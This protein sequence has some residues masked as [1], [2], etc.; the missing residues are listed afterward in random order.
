ME[1]VA[2]KI[3]SANRSY[4]RKIKEAVQ[5]LFFRHH[6]LPGVRGWEIRQELGPDWQEIIR[7]LDEQL[8]PLD[9]KVTRIYDEP[10]IIEKPTQTQL[11]NAR[12]YITMRSTL[13]QKIAKTI[14]W[15]VDDIAGLAVTVAYII[16]KQGKAPRIEVEKI[17]QEKLPGWRVKINLDRYIE[18]GY[19]GEQ[20][21]GVL[22]LEWRSRAEIDQKKLIALIM[23]FN[24]KRTTQ[25]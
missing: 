15:R 12:Y 17:L 6:R 25:V 20:D 8:V 19:L 18:Q 7:V 22:Y 23:A 2:R 3:E 5:I 14:G 13:D 16:S 4:S 10:D 24:Q 1:E 21:S 9:L 11:Q